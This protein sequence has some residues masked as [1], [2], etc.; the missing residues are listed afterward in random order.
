MEHLAVAEAG[1]DRLDAVIGTIRRRA[2]GALVVV[3]TTTT[4]VGA[5]ERLTAAPGGFGWVAV[6]LVATA[7]G[8]SR[9]VPANV[10]AVR[11]DSGQSFADAWN[12]ALS[13]P[14]GSLGRRR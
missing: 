1:G 4:T 8:E 5:L 12:R 2:T 11:V 3:T 14:A 13:A 7:P 9:P 6:V 10:L